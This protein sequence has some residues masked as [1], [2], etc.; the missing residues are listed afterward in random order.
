MALPQRALLKQSLHKALR[1]VN[2]DKN[3]SAALLKLKT[4]RT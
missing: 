3:I 4:C 2:P 1:S